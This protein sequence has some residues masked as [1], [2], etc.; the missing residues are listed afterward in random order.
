MGGPTSSYRSHSR[1]VPS[2]GM[3]GPGLC[4]PHFCFAS[5]LGLGSADP[6][7]R[8]PS[9]LFL[10]VCFHFLR[11]SPSTAVPL[12]QWGP[13][14]SDSRVPSVLCRWFAEPASS[15]LT[16]RHQLGG[17]L[18]RG[19]GTCSVGAVSELRVFSQVPVPRGPFSKLLNANNAGIFP[20]LSNPRVGRDPLQLL[21]PRSLSVTF[22]VTWLA[23]LYV[24]FSLLRQLGISV[25]QLNSDRRGR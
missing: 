18:T 15:R 4:K 3:L 25:S 10:P 21:P 9:S 22:P 1:P 7:G 23:V 5:G 6:V 14:C 11:P 8:Q 19:Q 13:S 20:R 12:Q 17:L 16:R 24:E 2:P